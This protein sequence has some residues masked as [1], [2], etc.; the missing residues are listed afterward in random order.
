VSVL[1]IFKFIDAEKTSFPIAFMCGRLGISKAG[2]YAWKH[3]PPA[4]RA[5]ADA[6]ITKLIHQIHAGS[7]G[8]YGAPRVHAELADEHGIR[9]GRKRVARLMRIANLR[10]VCRRRRVKTTRR[11]D[12]AQPSDDLVRRQFNAD[13]PN[14]LWIADI[15]YLPTWQGFLY[16][17]VVIDAYSRKVV[18]WSMANH[19]RTELVLD[20][21]EMALWNRRPGPGVIHHSDHGCQYTSLAFGR[22]CRETGI[23]ASMG[24]VGDCFDKT[25]AAHYTSFRRSGRFSLGRRG[26]NVWAPRRGSGPVG[27]RY[28]TEPLSS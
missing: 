5:V 28:R 23:A 7:R 4:D 1:D 25:C 13:Q 26:R 24:T 8:T 27:G 11:D 2:Y 18:G 21:L 15:T 9:C 12:Q 3:R 14:A 22:R 16:L 20:A 17:A 10:G 19:L 6:R